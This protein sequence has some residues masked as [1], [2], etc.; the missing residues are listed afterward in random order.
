MQR[1]APTG[2][3]L[4]LFVR[5]AGHDTPLAAWI[6]DPAGGHEF[7]LQPWVFAGSRIRPNTKSMGPGEHYVADYTGSVVGIVTFG[8]ETIACDHVYSDRVEVDPAE[9]QARTTSMPEP[10]T[11]VKLVLR[12]HRQD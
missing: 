9:W 1:I 6:H 4:D 11:P 5:V 7:P 12:P 2:A 3:R 8:D 10:G